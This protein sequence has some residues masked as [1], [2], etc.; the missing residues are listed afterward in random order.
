MKQVYPWAGVPSPEVFTVGG[1]SPPLSPGPAEEAHQLAW[2][3]LLP[4]RCQGSGEGN[5]ALAVWGP[6]PRCRLHRHS[7]PSRPLCGIMLRT[8]SGVWVK[9]L[10]YL[11]AVARWILKQLT[12]AKNRQLAR[13]LGFCQKVSGCCSL[14]SSRCLACGHRS[15]ARRQGLGVCPSASVQGTAVLGRALARP[16]VI[17]LHY[18]WSLLWFWAI[19]MLY[20]PPS[21][22]G[23]HCPTFTLEWQRQEQTEAQEVPSE[24]EE[25]LRPF[26]GDGALEQAAQGG[27]RVSF[28]GDIQTH[29]GCGPVQLAVGDPALAGGWTRWSTEVPSDTYDS[30][31]CCVSNPSSQIQEILRICVTIPFL[32][33]RSYPTATLISLS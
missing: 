4:L 5:P 16:T 31:I 25:E 7:S 20:H 26:E 6:C 33:S 30:V 2:Q 23:F 24:H 11:A 12:S 14:A 1:M 15:L 3:V 8:A 29:P 18:Q 32:Q 13:S 17:F 10:N 28:S 22:A 21:V 27:C 19:G 9:M